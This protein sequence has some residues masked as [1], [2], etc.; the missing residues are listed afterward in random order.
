MKKVMLLAVVLALA[1]I[2]HSQVSIGIH[3]N[4]IGASMKNTEDGQDFDLKNRISW[5]GGLVA[6]IPISYSLTFMPQLNVLSKGGKM[7]ES[8]TTDFG[9]TSVT[10]SIKADMK[11]TYVE[12]PLNIVYSTAG[13]EG[14]AGFFIG[15]GP[16][17]GLGL[18]GKFKG[19]YTVSAMG[20]TES[21]PIDTDIKFD[22]KNDDEVDA[23]DEDGHFKRLDF[24]ANVIAGYQLSNGVFIN[25]HY[26][27]SF[28]NIN[29]NAGVESKN[30]Y[31]GI[32]IGYFFGRQ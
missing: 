9:G 7:D 4:V 25:A 14:G 18:S 8:E 28:S 5:K 23:N 30:R 2:A 22:G 32:G 16:S 3:G 1:S 19:D 27:Y 24:G 31:F 10:E 26:N 6:Q 12:L 11:L 29:P 13:E 21:E 20:Q 17:I 15:L